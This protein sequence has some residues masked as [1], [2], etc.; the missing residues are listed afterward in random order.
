MRVCSATEVPMI[1]TVGNHD[2]E[3]A[4]V[5]N[6]STKVN[7]NKLN[8]ILGD[9]YFLTDIDETMLAA[10][11]NRHCVV[12]GFHVVSVIPQSSSP[13]TYSQP[14]KHGW[15]RR[16]LRLQKRIPISLFSC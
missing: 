15:T 12:N 8:T 10:E 6:A 2:V 4:Y 9:D 13:V 11:N 5:W 3:G 7:T 14:Q 16:L 1:F